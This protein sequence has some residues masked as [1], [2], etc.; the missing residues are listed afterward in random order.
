M[1]ITRKFNTWEEISYDDLNELPRGPKIFLSEIKKKGYEVILDTYNE[2]TDEDGKESYLYVTVVIDAEELAKKPKD[3]SK[4]SVKNEFDSLSKILEISLGVSIQ[5]KNEEQFAKKMLLNFKK[6]MKNTVFGS[7]IH[8]IRFKFLYKSF[9]EI[10]IIRKNTSNYYVNKD[11][12]KEYVSNKMIDDEATK[13]LA[14]VGY[15]NIHVDC[16]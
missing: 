11:G 8:Q 14:S 3:F 5:L 1:P 13:Y 9:L 12:E 2:T 15:P 10:R 6:Y 16:S 4:A 7:F